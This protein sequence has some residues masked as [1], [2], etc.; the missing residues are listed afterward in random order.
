MRLTHLGEPGRQLVGFR[1][2]SPKVG[3]VGFDSC[4]GASC[5]AFTGTPIRKRV[6][7]M[8]FFDAASPKRSC[9]GH[10]FRPRSHL[11]DGKL[12]PGLA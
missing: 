8:R 5:G 1:T 10:I 3:G 6:I 7:A 4:S 2:V 9:L 12:S 11:F